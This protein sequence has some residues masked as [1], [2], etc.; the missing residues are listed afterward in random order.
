METVYG[1]TETLAAENETSATHDTRLR[2]T[3][4][5]CNQLAS[6]NNC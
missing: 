3:M 6:K 1:E 2:A 5:L 4:T